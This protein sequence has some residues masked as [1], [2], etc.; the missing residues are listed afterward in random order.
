MVDE[1]SPS[2]WLERVEHAQQPGR[3]LERVLCLV[4]DEGLAQA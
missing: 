2:G 1:L 3:G 4:A